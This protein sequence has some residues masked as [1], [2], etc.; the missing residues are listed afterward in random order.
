MIINLRGTNGSGKSTIVRQVMS[1]FDMNPSR[2]I[3]R[4]QPI[5]YFSSNTDKP[6]LWV[7]G[8][9]ETDCGGC[10][11]ITSLDDVYSEIVK[12]KQ[13]G[14]NVLYEGIMASGEFRRCVQLHKQTHDVVV[15]ALDIPI[16]TCISAILERREQSG[17]LYKP[18]NAERTTRRMREVRSMMEHLKINNVPASWMKR[19]EALELCLKELGAV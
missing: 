3:G 2:A 10:D 6:K 15:I 8:H 11:T 7:V 19:E 9:Y 1:H 17:R 18:F 5:G 12:A 4:R 16:S 13:E 14:Y